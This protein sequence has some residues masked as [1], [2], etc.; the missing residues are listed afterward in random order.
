M[1]YCNIPGCEARNR[2]EIEVCIVFMHRESGKFSRF[3]IKLVK[4]MEVSLKLVEL[5]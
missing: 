1:V 3:Y 4:V 5:K 2:E